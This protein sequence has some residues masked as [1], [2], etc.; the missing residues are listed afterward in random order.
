MA[1]EYGEEFTVIQGIA[2]CVFEEN[3]S[4]VIVDYKTDR[5]P[6]HE[7]ALRRYRI[8]VDLYSEAVQAI[9]NRPV[10]ERYLYLLQSGQLVKVPS[11]GW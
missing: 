2:D 1:E 6:D 10:A 3:G 8:Q 9:L 7:K 11:V 4:L 5:S